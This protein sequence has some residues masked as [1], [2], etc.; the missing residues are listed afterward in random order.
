GLPVFSPY[1]TKLCWTSGRTSD[2]KS[3]LFMADWNH[4]AALDALRTA[5]SRQAAGRAA[6]AT[7]S[8]QSSEQP[9]LGQKPQGPDAALAQSPSHEFSTEISAGDLRAIVSYL[10]SDELAGRLSGSPGGRMAAEYIA[11][12]MQRIGLQPVGTNES[13][14]QPYEFN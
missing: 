12:Q 6:T 9:A 11:G 4:A 1:G 14:S 5:P 7:A 13:Y 2:G 3:Q 8:T 10:A